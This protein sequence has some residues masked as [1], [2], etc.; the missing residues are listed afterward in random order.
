VTDFAL[1]YGSGAILDVTERR[2]HL[3]SQ[4]KRADEALQ[5]KLLQD[6]FIDM[7]VCVP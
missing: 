7:L 6:H 1:A 2:Q 4:T 3:M 5:L